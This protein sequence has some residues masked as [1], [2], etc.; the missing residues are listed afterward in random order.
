MLN[1]YGYIHIQLQ[2]PRHSKASSL[3]CGGLRMVESRGL[4][5]PRRA[6]VR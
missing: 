4:R 5:A 1:M 2:A 3:P 6:R